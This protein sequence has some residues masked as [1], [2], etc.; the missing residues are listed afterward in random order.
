MSKLTLYFVAGNTYV[1][2][3]DDDESS[4]EEM[5]LSAHRSNFQM[6]THISGRDACVINWRH[7]M[8]AKK[9]K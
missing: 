7:V 9:D 4:L 2:N 1:L 5:L 8:Y 3:Y 6:T